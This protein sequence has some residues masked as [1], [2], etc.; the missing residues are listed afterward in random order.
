MVCNS[1]FVSR[2]GTPLVRFQFVTK[3]RRCGVSYSFVA[4]ARAL[5]D[6]VRITAIWMNI[7]GFIVM[8]GYGT[9]SP[10]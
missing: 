7:R 2:T 1:S 5:N 10:L 6:V 8:C 3:M 9:I 4:C